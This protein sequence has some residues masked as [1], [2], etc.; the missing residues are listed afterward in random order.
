MSPE[1]CYAVGSQVFKFG[2]HVHAASWLREA[3]YRL[4]DWGQSTSNLKVKIYRQLPAILH[5]IGF[6]NIA[7]S[8][9]TDLLKLQPNDT[10]ARANQIVLDNYLKNGGSS[11]DSSNSTLKSLQVS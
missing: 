1:D 3:F 8:M 11:I 4:D 5:K 9:T 7:L 2:D 6:I 10:N